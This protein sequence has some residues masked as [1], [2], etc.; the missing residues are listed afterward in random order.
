MIHDAAEDCLSL[1]VPSGLLAGWTAGRAYFLHN[2]LTNEP[3]GTEDHII[4]I[5]HPAV[6]ASRRAALPAVLEGDVPALL[7]LGPEAADAGYGSEASDEEGLP[8]LDD[9]A[10]S[11][12]PEDDERG[13]IDRVIRRR[14]EWLAALPAAAAV[15]SG[16]P[17]RGFVG[18][19]G[20]RRSTRHLRRAVPKQDRFASG[21]L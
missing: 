15:P 19:P 6:D 5:R 10:A 1:I 17:L 18:L 16:P 11:S 8:M 3:G 4:N 20:Q 9:E 7:D 2:G 13:V 14:D 12:G 21:V